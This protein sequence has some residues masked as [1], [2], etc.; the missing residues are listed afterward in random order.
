MH[1]YVYGDFREFVLY[2]LDTEESQMIF[3]LQ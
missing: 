2:L 1:V 3:Y